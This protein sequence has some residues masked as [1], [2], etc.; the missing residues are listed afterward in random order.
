MSEFMRRKLPIYYMGG[1]THLRRKLLKY[2]PRGLKHIGSPF[3]G[4]G[5]FE[6]FLTRVRGIEVVGN[7]YLFPLVNFWQHL[8]DDARSVAE[9]AK[10]DVPF[11]RAKY[12]A[13]NAEWRAAD[14]ML[15]WVQ[16]ASR[17]WIMHQGGTIARP[18]G[19]SP[20]KCAIFN[21]RSRSQI[22]TLGR[23]RVRLWRLRGLSQ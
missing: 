6:V 2:I 1:K 4:G 10:L 14:F 7:D 13:W 9:S 12:D 15:E 16:W 21:E 22:K 19:F 5:S 23:F 20:A 18:F 3:F 11:D 8:I 17:F